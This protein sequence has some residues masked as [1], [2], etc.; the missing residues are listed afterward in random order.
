M[1]VSSDLSSD[2]SFFHFPGCTLI[3]HF[4]QQPRLE[5]TLEVGPSVSFI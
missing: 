5:G 4:S 1:S 3:L 2:L